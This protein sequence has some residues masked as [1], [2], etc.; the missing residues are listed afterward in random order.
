MK[1]YIKHVNTVARVTQ[2]CNDWFSLEHENKYISKK[3]YWPSDLYFRPKDMKKII[4]HKNNGLLFSLF[5]A[6]KV[7]V[8]APSVKGERYCFTFKRIA[9]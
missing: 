2:W 4:N 9:K 3:I 1:A 5:R 7:I 8:G 6:E